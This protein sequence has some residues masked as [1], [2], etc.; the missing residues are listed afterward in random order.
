MALGLGWAF[1]RV[2]CLWFPVFEYLEEVFFF[3]LNESVGHAAL[4]SRLKVNN[5]MLHLWVFLKFIP[6]FLFS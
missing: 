3:F 2:N 6:S 5:K 1:G 4:E